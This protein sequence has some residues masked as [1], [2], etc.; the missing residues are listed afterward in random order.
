VLFAA[1]FVAFVVF[2]TVQYQPDI[3]AAE[4]QAAPKGP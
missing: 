3:R 1:L 2:D 4:T